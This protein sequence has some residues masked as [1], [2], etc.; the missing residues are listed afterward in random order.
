MKEQTPS[1]RYPTVPRA[2]SRQRGYGDRPTDL[3][4]T[5]A[6]PEPAMDRE[7]IT[8]A[9]VFSVPVGVGITGFAVYVMN[10][11]VLNPTATAVGLATTLVLFS[12]VAYATAVGS[13][14]ESR[15]RG[16]GR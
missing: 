2:R 12:I 16:D 9:L 14:D 6:D 5:D 4:G 15:Q 3:S 8:W 11:G 1:A 10:Q 13:A 7:A